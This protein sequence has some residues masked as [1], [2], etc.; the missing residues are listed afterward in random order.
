MREIVDHYHHCATCQHFGFRA[1]ENKKYPM[2]TRLGFD[3]KPE[4]QFDCW[5]PKPRVRA[6]IQKKLLN[7]NKMSS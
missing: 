7:Q 2:C 1:E 3:T 6:A 5:D 4:Y